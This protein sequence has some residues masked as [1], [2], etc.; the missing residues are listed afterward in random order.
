M[1]FLTFVLNG[2]DYGIPLKDV[3]SIEIKKDVMKV[4]T[5]PSHIIGIIR[6][7]GEIVPVFSLSSRFGVPEGR[8]ES[9]VVANVDGMKIGLE[10]EKVKEIVEVENRQVLPMPSLMNGVKNCFSD[11]ASRQKQ[12]FVLLDVASLVS[13]EEEQEI[14][15]LITDNTNY[16]S[17]R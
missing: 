1:Q 4:P 15:Q 3:E 11:V 13:M 6:L 10:V 17:E 7:H 2:I 14:R 5:A 16:S 8:I 9:L 12:L